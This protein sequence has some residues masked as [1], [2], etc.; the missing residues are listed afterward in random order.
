M[1]ASQIDDRD[2]NPLIKKVSSNKIEK[3]NKTPNS[4]LN[5]FSEIIDENDILNRMFSE[6]EPS[7]DRHF[8]DKT[9][10]IEKILKNNYDTI[11]KY[12]IE[13]MRLGYFV[14]YKV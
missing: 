3:V 13:E 12:T 11:K 9:Y 4:N 10:K 5:I 6:S 7:K 8:G 1:H 2:K 14:D